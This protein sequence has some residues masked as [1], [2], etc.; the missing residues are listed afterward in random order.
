[1]YADPQ[2]KSTDPSVLW[3]EAATYVQLRAPVVR[4]TKAAHLTARS[5]SLDCH[6]RCCPSQ[7]G[8][9]SGNTPPRTLA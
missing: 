7:R 9:V 5:P 1:M 6:F 4:F 3:F 2:V 8:P